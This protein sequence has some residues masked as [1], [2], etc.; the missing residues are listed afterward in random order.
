MR[1]GVAGYMGSGKTS[2]VHTFDSPDTFVIDADAQAKMLMQSDIQLQ[3]SL[4]SAFGESVL[5]SNGLNFSELGCR[6][7]QSLDTLVELNKIVHKPLVKHLEHFVLD[8]GKPLC[9]L[10]AALIPLWRVESWFDLCVWV[11]A[12]FEIRLKRLLRKRSGM[13]EDELRRRMRL[14]EDVMAV[15]REKQWIRLPDSQCRQYILD[16]IEI[17]TPDFKNRGNRKC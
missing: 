6:A 14:Q 3:F 11:E 10:D 13:R 9:I 1:I 4:K 8:N 12:P 17:K 16:H 15:P 7:F 2:C 5:D